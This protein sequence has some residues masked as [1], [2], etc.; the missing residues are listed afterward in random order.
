VKARW[1]SSLQNSSGGEGENRTQETRTPRPR[2]RKKRPAKVGYSNEG[3]GHVPTAGLAHE[4][5]PATD[6][7][8]SGGTWGDG[9]EPIQLTQW[10]RSHW[11][12]APGTMKSRVRKLRKPTNKVRRGSVEKGAGCKGRHFNGRIETKRALRVP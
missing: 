7:G 6:V 2:K 3:R 8:S 10:E 4:A 12:V 5:S 11:W 1:G 9:Q